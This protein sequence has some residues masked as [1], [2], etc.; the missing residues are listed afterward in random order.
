[1]MDEYEERAAIIQYDGKVPRAQAEFEAAC[2]MAEKYD[3]DVRVFS[4]P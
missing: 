4:K 1:M 3:V 2:Q